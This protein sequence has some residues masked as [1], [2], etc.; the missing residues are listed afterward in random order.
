MSFT[1]EAQRAQSYTER[2]FLRPLYEFSVP[3]VPLW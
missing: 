2:I 3:S 1:T